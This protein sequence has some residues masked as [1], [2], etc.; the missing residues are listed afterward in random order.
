MFESA[1]TSASAGTTCGRHTARV[2]G[3]VSAMF[4]RSSID[5]T[6]FEKYHR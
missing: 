1:T 5:P 3:A 2:F 6:F 4:A